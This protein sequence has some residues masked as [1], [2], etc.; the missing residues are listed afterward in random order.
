MKWQ[1]FVSNTPGHDGQLHPILNSITIG[2]SLD[3]L[4]ILP[5]NIN[6]SKYM[7]WVEQLVQRD[8]SQL[9]YNSNNSSWYLEKGVEIEEG[10][11]Y[12]WGGASIVAMCVN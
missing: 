10:K 7:K 4:H 8:L 11:L 3:S 9:R 12:K 6:Q 1:A 5:Q 2:T